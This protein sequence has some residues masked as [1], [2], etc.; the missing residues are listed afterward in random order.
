ML[1][2]V[3]NKKAN[4][5]VYSPTKLAP[6]V[7]AIRGGMSARKAASLYGVPKSTLLDRVH[8]RY[9]TKVIQNCKSQYMVF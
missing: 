5:R 8:G 6:A 7:A 1:R 4:Y 3:E 2:A 9:I